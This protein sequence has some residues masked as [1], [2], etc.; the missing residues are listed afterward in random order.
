MKGTIYSQYKQI[1]WFM[2]L[3]NKVKILSK[4]DNAVVFNAFHQFILLKFNSMR[5]CLDIVEV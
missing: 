1:N 3:I 2:L 4:L 5:E